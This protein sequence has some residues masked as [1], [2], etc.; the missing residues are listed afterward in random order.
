M[1]WVCLVGGAE[2]G[3]VV[4]VDGLKG[5]TVFER[6]N[7]Y[8]VVVNPGCKSNCLRGA[9]KICQGLD[10]TARDCLGWGLWVILLTS[11]D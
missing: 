10:C 6:S 5:Y 7:F 3:V 8:L 1:G 2:A 11:Q 4:V 9:S